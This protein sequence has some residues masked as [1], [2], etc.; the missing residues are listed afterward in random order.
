MAPATRPISSW[1]SLQDAGLKVALGDA[2]GDI[3]DA[4][5]A[6]SGPIRGDR[7]YQKGKEERQSGS[8]FQPAANLQGHGF[9]VGERI[10]QADGAAGDGNG[11]VKKWNAD[12]RAAALVYTNAARESGGELFALRQVFDRTRGGFGISQHVAGG[13]DDGD[14]SAGGLPFLSGDVREGVAVVG[15]DSVGEKLSLLNQ[16]AFNLSAE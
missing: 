15:F 13:I 5:E 16:V 10:G 7:G 3:D 12:G 11:H 1:R 2:G 8:E 4:F 6:A 14:T 9:D